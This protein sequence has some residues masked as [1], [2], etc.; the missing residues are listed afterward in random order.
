M[1]CDGAE[2]GGAGGVRLGVAKD[3]IVRGFQV[4]PP[5]W[6]TSIALFEFIPRLALAGGHRR[7]LTDVHAGRILDGVSA[8]RAPGCR[9]S[10]LG[11]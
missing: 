7:L 2:A 10:V 4:I 6:P 1:R 8:T 5:V 11:S 3:C 9:V